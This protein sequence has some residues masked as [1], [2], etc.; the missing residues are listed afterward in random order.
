MWFVLI[1]GFLQTLPLF[2]GITTAAVRVV[3]R[4]FRLYHYLVVLRRPQ[5]ELFGGRRTM[6]MAAVVRA[7]DG[8]HTMSIRL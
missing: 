1:N 2:G 7:C 4:L 5:Y 3:R 8:R 6:C